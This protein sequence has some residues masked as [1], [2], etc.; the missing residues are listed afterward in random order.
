[1]Y[2]LWSDF[3]RQVAALDDFRRRVE[4]AFEAGPAA[5]SPGR[6]WMPANVYDTGADFVVTADLPGIRSGDVE[7][8]ATSDV[9][10]LTGRR[11]LELPEGY[12]LH[13]QERRAVKFSRSFSFPCEID[14]ERVSAALSDGV[15][16]VR[17]AKAENARPRQIAIKA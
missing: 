7:L 17:L 16:T 13:R 2:R 8:S 3:D 14:P 12:S 9:L 11:Q 4:Q 15:L 5:A 6:G 10:T 1:M